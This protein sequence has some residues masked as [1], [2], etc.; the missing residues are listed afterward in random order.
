MRI[1]KDQFFGLPFMNDMLKDLGAPP[2][3]KQKPKKTVPK[4]KEPVVEP[5][6]VE[7]SAS[8]EEPQSVEDPVSFDEPAS[9]DESASAEEPINETSA[10]KAKK[11]G[12]NKMVR[13]DISHL[14]TYTK[15]ISGFDYDFHI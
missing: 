14:P 5:P 1:E 10:G 8:V 13:K 3:K 7:E 2:R 15:R 12:S 6:S 11:D 4:I 9:V